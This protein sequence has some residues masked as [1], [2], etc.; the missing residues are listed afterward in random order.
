VADGPLAG[1][2][3]VVT[4]P[5]AQAGPLADGLADLGAT[6]TLIP[7]VAIEPAEDTAP[8]QAAVR[9][10]EDYDWVV[11]T[12]ANGV[13]ALGRALAGRPLRGPKVAAVGPA[14]ADAVRALGAEVAFVPAIFAAEDVAAGLG[15]VSGA[16]VLL[17]QADAA[18]P[19]LAIELRA[20]GAIVDAIVAYKTVAVEPT[21]AVREELERGADAIVL[22]SG[23]AVHSLATL[24]VDVAGRAL[25]VCIGPR[26]A[27][28]ARDAG[29]PVGLVAD[30]ASAEGI[31]QALMTHF[32]ESR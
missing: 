19:D 21:P 10:L 26:T 29:L 11:L 4:R 2:R 13:A 15:P 8:L 25:L 23:S 5:R 27:D 31:I 1:R 12:S 22:A 3:I 20:R 30:E 16:K 32:E 24:D 9:E 17:P 18:S 6:V 14:T 7:L 28:A